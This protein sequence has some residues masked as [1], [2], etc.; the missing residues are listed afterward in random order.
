[1]P[2]TR[3][4]LQRHER[5]SIRNVAV[6]REGPDGPRKSGVEV[7]ILYSTVALEQEVAYEAFRRRRQFGKF[8]ANPIAGTHDQVA[9]VHSRQQLARVP[10]AGVDPLEVVPLP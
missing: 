9:V 3:I 2:V 10:E 6:E 7:A 4:P 5:S 1:R 8:E